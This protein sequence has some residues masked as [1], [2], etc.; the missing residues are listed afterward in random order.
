MFGNVLPSLGVGALAAVV[1]FVLDPSPSWWLVGLI[2]AV[3]LIVNPCRN[4]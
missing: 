1:T 4:R 3:V 2:V